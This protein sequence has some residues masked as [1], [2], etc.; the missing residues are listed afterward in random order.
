MTQANWNFEKISMM[1]R[2]S[3]QNQ[4][5]SISCV[6][7]EC[8]SPVSISLTPSEFEDWIED[9]EHHVCSSCGE[10]V[11]VEGLS[12]VCY[13]CDAELD[14]IDLWHIPELLS[15]R[16]P[17]CAGRAEWQ[18]DF[19]S[20]VVSGSWSEAFG[21]YDWSEE[22]K[23][24]SGLERKGRTDYWEGLVHFCSAEEFIAI[25]KER[26]VRAF[27]TG[28][29]NKKHPNDTKAVCLTETTYPNWQELKDTHGSYGFV[30]RKRDII[31]LNGAPAIYLPQTIIE[32]LKG[33][34]E[35]IP[36]PLWPYLTKLKLPSKESSGKHDFLHEREWRVPKDIP[37]STALPFAVTFP[38]NRPRI[39][40]EELIIQ[41]A[42]EFHELV[43]TNSSFENF[44]GS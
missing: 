8:D 6:N 13:I 16:C 43:N 30:F 31:R 40:N 3:G 14:F 39:E 32:I 25:Y 2:A 44:D 15:E 26:R 33:S 12:I 42:Y 41:A 4:K 34:N 24:M 27:S 5:I 10:A 22:A 1:N 37:F 28:L 9:S 20:V 11:V 7:Y 17:N 35:L 23:S 36:K 21:V 29:Y 18:V 19:F 38:K